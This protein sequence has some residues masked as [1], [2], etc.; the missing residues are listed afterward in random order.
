[1]PS[2]LHCHILARKTL[3][4]VDQCSLQQISN[5]AQRGTSCLLVL[6]QCTRDR[7]IAFNAKDFPIFLVARMTN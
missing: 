5:Y 6:V 3:T 2:L 7:R 1:V 4:L